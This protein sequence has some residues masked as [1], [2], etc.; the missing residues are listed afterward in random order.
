VRILGSRL[1]G[2]HQIDGEFLNVL[3]YQNLAAGGFELQDGIAIDDLFELGLVAMNGAVDDAVQVVTG[4]IEHQD[5][6]E[7]AIELGFGKRVGAFHLDGILRGHHQE[8]RFE[9][10]RCGAAGN[11]AFLHGFEQCGLRFRSGAVD[12]VGEDEVGE[13][14]AGLKAEGFRAAI[15]RFDNH[16]SDDV[17]GHEVRSELDARIFEV[18]DA[19]ERSEQRGFAEAGYAFEQ[20]VAAG[21]EAD[22]DAID[23]LL[24][25]DDDFADLIAHLIEVAGGELEG[26]AGMHLFI[27][28]VRGVGREMGERRA[29]ECRDDS[30]PF[31]TEE[32][33]NC[34]R[35][36]DLR[37]TLRGG[38]RESGQSRPLPSSARVDKPAKRKIRF[39]ARHD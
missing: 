34:F 22:E 20:N 37:Q 7:E 3:G 32:M 28:T 30:V 24:L 15:V 29:L 39:R 16:T 1:R 17:G 35:E 4:R 25:A 21:E 9:F 36:R 38:R 12:L 26:R 8:W 5:L 23:H 11:G 13:D 10:M 19:A 33:P 27:L 14:G 18:Q 2:H 6:H 31:F